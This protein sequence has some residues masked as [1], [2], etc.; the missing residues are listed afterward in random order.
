MSR[1]ADDY[2]TS[3][4][5]ERALYAVAMAID[6]LAVQ[7]K[8]L[9]NGDAAT[10]MGAIEALGKVIKECLGA[11]ASGSLVHRTIHRIHRLHG[12]CDAA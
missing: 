8:Y 4:G 10:R 9:G 12:M 11:V 2:E 3:D 7:V 5:I 1:L 6:S